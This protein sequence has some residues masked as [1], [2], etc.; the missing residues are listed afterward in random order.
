MASGV[1]TPELKEHW[2][3]DGWCVVPG[4]IPPEPLAAA[5][6][7]LLRLFPAP[8]QMAERP[9]TGP[10]EMAH[11]GRTMA[12]VPVPQLPSERACPP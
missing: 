9:R 2:D 3:V 1:L 7:A 6:E 5:Q 4:A 10:G 8:A 12:G 11:L